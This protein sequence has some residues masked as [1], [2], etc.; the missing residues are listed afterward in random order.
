[1]RVPRIYT[2]QELSSGTELELEQAPSHHLL[3]V[4]RMDV[5]RSLILFNGRGGE[6]DASIIASSKKAATLAVGEFR[7]NNNESPLKSVLAIGLSRGERFDLVLQKAT[8][9]GVS[10]IQPLFTERCE[11]KL[12]GERLQK[13]AASWQ[14]IIIA[15]CEQSQR[16]ILAELKPAISLAEF[17]KQQ[18]DCELKLVL[19][20]RNSQR[21]SDLPTASSACFLIGPEGGL[22]EAEIHAAHSA[23]FQNLALGPR[24]L[25]TET[26]PLTALA[27]AQQYWGDF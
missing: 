2:E 15:A 10:I 12:R 24:V 21:F 3:K 18:L 26:A 23:G 6:F 11:V 4:L 20:H 1:M 8:E 5:G 14:K 17:Y 19:H 22:S 9:L 7:Q 27:L 16:N 13:K 25:R